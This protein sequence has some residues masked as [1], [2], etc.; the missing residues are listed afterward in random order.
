MFYN[1]Q[2]DLRQLDNQTVDNLRD[3]VEIYYTRKATDLA[4]VETQID[5]IIKL[6]RRKLMLMQIIYKP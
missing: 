6:S 3:H 1:F 4:D 2:A 5:T